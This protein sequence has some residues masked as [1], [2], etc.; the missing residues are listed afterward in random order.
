MTEIIYRHKYIYM[1]LHEKTFQN[2]GHE[3]SVAVGL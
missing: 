2:E 3:N 1:L